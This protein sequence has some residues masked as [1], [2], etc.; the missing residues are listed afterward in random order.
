[1]SRYTVG[2]PLWYTNCQACGRT[3][4]DP[5]EGSTADFNYWSGQYHRGGC[6]DTLFGTCACCGQ[7]NMAVL[8]NNAADAWPLHPDWREPLCDECHSKKY[9]WGVVTIVGRF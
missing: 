5:P 2:H 8:S 4:A 3:K 1:M 9:Q 6:Y 7:K